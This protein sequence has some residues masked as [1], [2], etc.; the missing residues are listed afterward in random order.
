MKASLLQASLLLTSACAAAAAMW[1]NQMVVSP[2]NWNV[3]SNWTAPA[4]FPNTNGAVALLSN[5]IPGDQTICLNVAIT[6]GTLIIGA[7]NG[8]SAFTLT[9]NGGSLI[10]ENGGN[11]A[12]LTETATSRGDFIQ[13]DAL[14]SDALIVTNAATNALTL[15]G[16]L[17][18]PGGWTK[19][20]AG[21][22]ILK[23]ASRYAGATTIQSGTVQLQGGIVLSPVAGYARW[24]DASTTNRVTLNASNL[25]RQWSDLSANQAHATPQTGFSPTYVTNALNGLGAIH[26]GPGP[27]D[28]PTN[29][30]SLNFTRDTTVRSVF[31]LFKGASF[32]LTDTNNYDFHRPTDTDPRSPLW[33]GAPN[34]WTSANIRNGATYVNGAAVDGTT[35]AM[36]TNLNRGFNLVEMMAAGNVVAN[37][38]NRD[39]VYHCGDQWQAEVLI[40]DTGLSDANRLA[41]EQY[42][43][44]KWFGYGGNNTLPVETD[45]TLATGATLD[46]CDTHQAVNSLTGAEGS[47]VDNSA[48]HPVRLTVNGNAVST[49]LAGALKNTGGGALSLIKNGTGALALSGA[50]A[51][52]GPTFVNLG[53]LFVSGALGPGAVTVSANGTLAGTGVING[54]VTLLSGA[55]LA[56][57]GSSAGTLTL[58]TNLVVNSGAQLAFALG[59][60]SSRLMLTGS[61]TI[62]G[63]VNVTDAGG[64]SEGTYLLVSG[65]GSLTWNAPQVGSL[66]GGFAATFD[67]NTP[68]QLKLVVTSSPFRRWQIQYFGNPNLPSAAPDADPDS[69]GVSNENEFLAGTNPTNRNSAFRLLWATKE[70][71]GMRLTWS[72]AGVRSNV[73]QSAPELYDASFNDLSGSIALPNAGETV[74][75]Y[76]DVA[77]ATNPGVRFYRVR[78]DPPPTL[79]ADQRIAWWRAARFGM[80]IHWDMSS[81]DAVEISWS[82]NSVGTNVYDNLYKEFNPTNFNADQWVALAQAAGMKY[83]VFTSR[84]HGGF[85]MFDTQATNYMS[86]I[87]TTNSYKITAPECPFGR[88]VVK[89]L[90]AAAHRAG[91]RFGT[92]YSQPDWV[93]TGSAND[94]QAYLKKQVGELMSHYGRIDVLWF[95][96]LGGSASTY[97]SSNLNA[98]ARSWQ[99]ALLINNRDNFAEDFDTPEQKVGTFQNTRAWE[100]CMTVSAHNHWSWAGT[101]DG[102]KSLAT[103]LGMLVNCA[104]GDGNML[105]DVGPR[106]DGIIDPAQA[107]LLRQ[108]GAWLQTNGESI[109]STRGGPFKPGS[110]GACTYRTNMVYLHILNWTSDPVVLPPI[111]ARILSS[112]VLTGG[113]AS[114]V[115]SDQDIE[116]TVPAADRQ[117]IDT[118]VVLQLDLDAGLLT[119]V[120]V[121][122]PVSLAQGANA[123]ASNVYQNNATYAA[124]KAVDGNLTTRWATDNGATNAWL[125]VDMGTPRT[126][127]RCVINEAYPGRVQSFQLQWFD[128]TVWQTFWSGTTLS[129]N[130]SQ[131]F[132]PVTA[133]LV[134]LNILNASVGPTI[135]EFQLY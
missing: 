110:Y 106:A 113:S 38:F 135:W 105:L 121:P 72:A 59:T 29:S 128:G 123:T 44:H 99:P 64:F 79:T 22:V 102:V 112:R 84:H 131:T 55:G 45:L 78:L 12:I 65:F 104:G 77:A 25:V 62:G 1:T 80:F 85:S 108:M 40:Y 91:L 124:S 43:N 82:R 7:A 68:G 89:E 117:V 94:Y 27:N 6:N 126:F 119:P 103:C 74:T 76:L 34:Y 14:L 47:V 75:N 54:A 63:T 9:G 71:G 56:P 11:P 4:I 57:G 83:M 118:I 107:G 32:L 60:N 28:Q 19:S 98:L 66:P 115:Q 134:R 133:Q 92:Y 42:F 125:Q 58:T 10:F 49:T 130:W 122:T 13:A 8:S 16:K 67:T 37:G 17:S 48:A 120:D 52:S 31:S 70:S 36:P 81:V 15:A 96:G 61:L 3:N 53:T 127:S 86:D 114:V 20:G 73:L 132:P 26:F 35:F 33:V 46:L 18:G 24:F 41:V 50:N 88:D 97:D 23:G 95:D 30:D 93:F 2:Q 111:P 69:D 100:S 90:S 129:A 101:N 39:R 109:Y 5:D 87:G 21:L 51:N 116:I